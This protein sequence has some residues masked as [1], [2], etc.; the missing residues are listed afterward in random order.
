VRELAYVEQNQAAGRG[1]PFCAELHG[2]MDG[3]R[4]VHAGAHWVGFVPAYARYPYQVRLTPRRHTPAIDGIGGIDG[5]GEEAVELASILPRLVRAYNAAFQA[6][7]PYMLALHQLAD[8]RFHFHIEL[9]PVGRAPGK[10]K[11]AASSE[12]AWNFW[13]NDSFPEVKAAE[14]RELLAKERAV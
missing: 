10:L 13:M 8:A 7:M 4:L 9:L 1:C 3:P 12:M 6:P 2:E 11:L 14:L 5:E